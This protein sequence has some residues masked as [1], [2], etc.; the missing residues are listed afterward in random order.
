MRN[1]GRKID[2]DQAYRLLRTL[3]EKVEGSINIR[4]FNPDKKKHEE[5]K[6]WWIPLSG[7]KTFLKDVRVYQ[8]CDLYFSLATMKNGMG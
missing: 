8:G 2:V 1:D 5:T 7:L 3:F 6:N 4:R